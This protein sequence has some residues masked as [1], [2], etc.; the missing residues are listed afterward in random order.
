M[1]LRRPSKHMMA[2]VRQDASK[3]DAARAGLNRPSKF[4]D[5]HTAVEEGLAKWT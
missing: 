3:D 1:E 5:S 4:A 2:I